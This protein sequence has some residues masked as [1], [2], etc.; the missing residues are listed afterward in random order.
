[1]KAYLASVGV[2]PGRY[3]DTVLNQVIATEQAAQAHKCHTVRP[4]P[5]LEALSRRVQ[6]NLAKRGLP[7]GVIEQS[8]DADGR[9]FMPTFDPEIR[10]L[11]A[12]YRRIVIG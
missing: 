8:G 1:V 10:R 11:E 3:S 2:P 4:A 7:L 6:V 9:P 5:M 12:P